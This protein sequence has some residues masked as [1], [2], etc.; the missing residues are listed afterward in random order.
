MY[1]FRQKMVLGIPKINEKNYESE[2]IALNESDVTCYIFHFIRFHDNNGNLHVFFS[3]NKRA[4]QKVKNNKNKFIQSFIHSFIKASPFIL[5]LSHSISLYFHVKY[6]KQCIAAGLVVTVAK[7][8]ET[9][10]FIIIK[11]KTLCSI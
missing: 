1:V 5:P 8:T 9:L 4:R 10:F 2:N 7:M 6:S 11:P 3:L